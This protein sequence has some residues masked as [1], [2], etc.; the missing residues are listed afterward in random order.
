MNKILL[1][2]ENSVLNWILRRKAKFVYIRVDINDRFGLEVQG[3]HR[4]GDVLNWTL[5][6]NGIPAVTTDN[7]EDIIKRVTK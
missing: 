5:Y 2:I 3:D 7:L 4:A 1:A 6:D